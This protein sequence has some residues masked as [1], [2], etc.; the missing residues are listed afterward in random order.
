MATIEELQ[1]DRATLMAKRAALLA[2]ELVKE[3]WRDGRRLI[4]GAPN[5]ADFDKAI[6]AID[7]EIAGLTNEAAGRP[8][9]RA[10]TLSF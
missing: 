9:R 4:F 2:G 8:R 7:T 6:A 10:I 1:A 5:L 3:V